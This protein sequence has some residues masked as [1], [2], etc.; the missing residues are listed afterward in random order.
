[1]I[2]RIGIMRTKEEILEWLSA[3]NWYPRYRECF[4]H[5]SL[6]YSFEWLL[7]HR[8]TKILRWAFSWRD[9]REGFD[10]WHRRSGELID[11]LGENED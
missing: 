8:P 6:D 3:Q 4:G 7:E 2:I 1:M 10:T 9:T 5:N 11:F